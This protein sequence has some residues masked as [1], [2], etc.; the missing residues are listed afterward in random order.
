MHINFDIHKHSTG[1]LFASAVFIFLFVSCVKTREIILP[2]EKDKLVINCLFTT[3]SIWKINISASKS[4]VNTS[5]R[6]TQINN[7]TVQLYG[8][9]LFIG[10]LTNIGKGNYILN[11]TPQFGKKYKLVVTAPDYD[12]VYAEDSITQPAGNITYADINTKE[13][14]QTMDHKP[15]Y[16]NYSVH[17]VNLQIKDNT[18]EANFYRVSI[19]RELTDTAQLALIK[20][21]FP[22]TTL[23]IF[24]N[25]FSDDQTLKPV[26]SEQGFL[27]F[28]NDYFKSQHKS[29]IANTTTDIYQQILG[30]QDSSKVPPNDVF[31]VNSIQQYNNTSIIAHINYDLYLEL[32]TISRTYYNYSYSLLQQVQAV[33][34]PF[35]EFKNVYTNV[36]GG[37]GIFAGY[38]TTRKKVN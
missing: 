7:A 27:L 19:I 6:F 30:Y 32:R 28:P 38:Q 11:T 31:S 23:Y 18:D 15:P 3:D 4:V 25:V 16:L 10:T 29:I 2:Q 33:S 22:I 24:F 26:S 20:K 36:K 17:P 34:D 5:M 21:T 12:P 37:Y 35:A 8:N 1:K 14:I 13:T 9:E